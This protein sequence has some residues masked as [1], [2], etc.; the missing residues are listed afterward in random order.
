MTD[1]DVIASLDDALRAAASAALA[2]S[3]QRYFPEPVAALGVSNATVASIAA[4]AVARAPALGL[5]DW[6]RIADHFARRGGYHEHMMLASALLAKVAR[7]PDPDG[8]LLVLMT[9][10]LER[11]V[12]NWAQCD[13][14]CIKPL[15]AYLRRHPQLLAGVYDWGRLGSPWLRRASNVALVKFVGRSEFV[16]LASV[17]ANCA[18]LLA[19]PDPY[20]QKAIG[21]CLKVASQYEPDAVLAFLRHHRAGMARSTLRYATEK[22]P[23]EIRLALRS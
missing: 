6:A 5:E 14:L 20:V 4:G 17:L 16:D 21:W 22:L 3:L 2:L 19:D 7:C 15:Y 8:R 1:D 12:S 23:A 13:D 11:H 18:R 10:W 9:G